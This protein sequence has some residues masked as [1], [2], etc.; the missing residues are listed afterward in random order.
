MSVLFKC[1][2]R[3]EL[4]PDNPMQL[5]RVKDVSKR[6]ERPS[7][8]TADEFHK[9]LPHVRDPCR[10]MVLIAGSLRLRAGEIEGLQWD[11]FNFEKSTLLVQRGIVHGRVET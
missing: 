10:T 8:L 1:A 5:V 6:L 4:I 9:L 7:V 11:D 3:W 2:Q